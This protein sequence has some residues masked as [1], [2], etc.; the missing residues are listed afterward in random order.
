V[1]GFSADQRWKTHGAQIVYGYRFERGHTII[2]D[3]ANDPVPFDFVSNLAA[4]NLAT[5]LDR[6]D[7]PLASRKGTFS[8][9]SLDQSALWLGSDVS[10]L[11]VL[12][13]QYVFVPVGGVVL[14]SRV[15]AGKKFGRDDLFLDDRF[16]AG[17]ATSVRGY[18]EDSLGPRGSDGVPFGG[19]TML[20][21]NQEV[22]FPIR[23]W[24]SGVGFV[25]AGDVLGKDETLSSL[26]VGYGMGL[27]F[28]TPVG[29]L[30]VD[31]GI[32]YTKVST[33]S[34]REPNSLRDGRWYFGIGHIF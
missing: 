1:Q 10:N 20:V 2:P 7:D 28:N 16:R 3:S 11:K 25:D 4:L 33:L 24:V 27:R 26:M 32:P 12:A 9:V 30:R 34:T 17:G 8:S 5:L 13:Q 14:A 15:Q 31:F 29:L 21:I 19:E 23:G 18:S 22:R 6:R